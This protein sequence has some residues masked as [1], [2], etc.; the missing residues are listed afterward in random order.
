MACSPSCNEEWSSVQWMIHWRQ[1]ISS[2]KLSAGHHNK[3]QEVGHWVGA[4]QGWSYRY[5]RTLSLLPPTCFWPSM[6]TY[7]AAHIEDWPRHLFCKHPADQGCHKRMSLQPCQW[8]LVCIDYLNLK[9]SKG[10]CENVLMVTNHVIKY[11]QSCPTK[12]QIATLTAQVLFNNVFVYY[13]F[14]ACLRRN[15]QSKVI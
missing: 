2:E 4:W 1:R 8:I 10:G 7:V 6:T 15:I 5:E 13:G 11:F 14:P 9:S 3:L 12:N